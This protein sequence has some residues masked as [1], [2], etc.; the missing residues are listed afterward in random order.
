MSLED[1]D[2]DEIEEEA[3]DNENMHSPNHSQLTS[4]LT[5]AA[6]MTPNFHSKTP[7][8][9]Q[10][11]T[12]N[13][14]SKNAFTESILKHQDHLKDI[15]LDF[16]IPSLEA[17]IPVAFTTCQANND[18]FTRAKNA[19]LLG[20]SATQTLSEQMSF[21]AVTCKVEGSPKRPVLIL[22]DDQDIFDTLASAFRFAERGA[23]LCVIV[24]ERCVVS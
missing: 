15:T 4:S 22:W 8:E 16:I 3:D 24:E 12:E 2:L 14:P 11:L 13:N 9:H 6:S 7:L 17:A 20:A 1:S 5:S 23:G 18:F 21:K 19:W 10:N